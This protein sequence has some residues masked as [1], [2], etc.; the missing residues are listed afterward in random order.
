LKF[1]AGTYRWR[2]PPNYEFSLN[3]RPWSTSRSTI[4]FPDLREGKYELGLRVNDD[5]GPVGSET[6]LVF[7]ILPPWYRTWLAFLACPVAVAGLVFALIRFFV[8]RAEARNAQLEKVVAERATELKAAMQK[9]QIEAETTAT[10]AERN[11]LAGE[12]HDSLE[13]GFTGL[14]LQLETTANFKSC[15]TEVKAGLGAALNMIAFSRKEVRH[16]VR[17]LHSPILDS[18]DLETALRQVVIQNMPEANHAT[19]QTIGARTKLGSSVEHHLLRIAQEAVTN[20]V[21]HANANRVEI[22]LAFEAEHVQLTIRDDGCG[23]EPGAVLNGNG[24]HFGLPS[25][26]DRASAMGGTVEIDCRPRA[27]TQI[28]VRVPLAGTPT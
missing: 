25:F 11:R 9:L 8:R 18:V 1:F 26:R 10:L 5:R 2:R 3:G 20:T 28:T 15:S 12:I 4:E 6:H 21:K 22:V 23:F 7:S 16:A 27:G 24:S 13:Q 14:K 17:N 19:I